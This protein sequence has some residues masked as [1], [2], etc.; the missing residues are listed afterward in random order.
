MSSSE[1]VIVQIRDYLKRRFGENA[2]LPI[3]WEADTSHTPNTDRSLS[4]TRHFIGI[5][6]TLTSIQVRV[7]SGTPR[8]DVFLRAVL[9]D[10]SQNERAVLFTGYLD[11][12]IPLS[13]TGALPIKSTW[14]I[15]LESWSSMSIAPILRL[16][17][18]ALQGISNVGGWSGT[19]ES[20]INGAGK[21]TT[22]APSDGTVS[23]N[24]TITVPTGARYRFKSMKFDFNASSTVNTRTVQVIFDNG[25]TNIHTAVS[26]VT[27]T[28]GLTRSYDLGAG[29]PA[30]TSALG[31]DIRIPVPNE[32][33][34]LAGSRIRTNIAN[35]STGD[36]VINI[37]VQIDEWIEP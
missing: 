6:G 7:I 28:A 26:A 9:E 34:L 12:T 22:L 29:L 3:I 14:R 11:A 25:T 24:I 4:T 31:S 15:R 36:Q 5:E 21:V 17:G 27:Q 30:D 13:G 23:Q 8:R 2:G 37:G 20:S 19:S 1:P 32:L 18:T 35:L 10:E 33:V 16:T